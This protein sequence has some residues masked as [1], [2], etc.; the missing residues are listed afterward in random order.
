MFIISLTTLVNCK[1]TGSNWKQILFY[2]EFT[3][4]CKKKEITEIKL[5][6]FLVYF[7]K[8]HLTAHHI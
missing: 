3:V 1:T 6:V 2:I 5:R 8:Y 7:E 4:I